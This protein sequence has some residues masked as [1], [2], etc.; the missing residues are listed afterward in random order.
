VTWDYRCPYGRIVHDHVVTGLLAGADWNVTFLPYCLGQS[1]RD[2][3]LPPIWETPQADSGLFAL[4]VGVAARDADPARFP[5]FHHAV[6]EDRHTRAGNLNDRDAIA[7]M[8]TDAGLDASTVFDHVE[9]GKPL[10]TIARE[11]MQYVNSHD[12]WGVPTFVVDDKA[13]F[14]RLL[15][16]SDGNAETAIATIDRILD[17]IDWPILNEFKHTSVPQ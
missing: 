13:V 5:T 16:T 6:Y 3:G 14:V 11:H 15:R 1:N 8:L 2:P 12:V 7:A 9:S 17:N 10:R 4:Q